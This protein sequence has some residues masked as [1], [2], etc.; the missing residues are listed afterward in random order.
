MNAFDYLQIF[1]TVIVLGVWAFMLITARNVP[2]EVYALVGAVTGYFFRSATIAIE[3]RITAYM[4]AH[5]GNGAH[6]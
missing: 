1:V 3:K 4:E 6:D 5:K 2:P